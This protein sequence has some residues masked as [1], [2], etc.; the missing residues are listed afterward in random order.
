MKRLS[1]IAPGLV[2]VAS[3]AACA[4]PGGMP[5]APEAHSQYR[6]I[7]PA[8]DEDGSV[9]DKLR[10]IEELAIDDFR[11]NTFIGSRGDL[12]PYRLLP[13]SVVVE[14][15]TYPLIVVFHG[16]GEIGVDNVGQMDRFPRY[17]LRESIREE[18]PAFV[19]AP[20]MPER[21]SN[22][23]GPQ[24]DEVR[25]SEP[26]RPLETALELIDSISSENPI[27][28]S[29]IYSIGF[30]MGASTAMNALYLR[31][32]FFAA[33]IA[34][35][36]VPNEAHAPDVA[37]TPLWLVHGT[38]DTANSVHHTRMM[39]ERLRG[40]GAPVVFWEFDEA[41]HVVPAE[42]LAGDFFARWLFLQQRRGR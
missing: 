16:A 3:M 21:S 1:W 10:R 33:S 14:G 5:Q 24:E 18:Y 38:Y 36:G 15:E 13:P 8:G 41:H 11:A 17:W 7:E 23:S 37:R 31:P 35:G 30:S 9:Q 22:Y 6:L 32:G 20:Q 27:D 40:M 34:I 12:L 4:G 2:I 19:L 28:A 39:Y 42:L 26:G 29:R 25:Y